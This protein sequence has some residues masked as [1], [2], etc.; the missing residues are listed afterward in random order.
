MDKS[1]KAL[2]PCKT[3]PWR[4]KNNATIIPRYDHNKACDLTATVSRGDDLRP[5]MACHKSTDKTMIA[6]K[7]Y[8]AREGWSNINVR[9]MLLHGQIDNPSDVMGAIEANGVELEM[10]YD[11]VLKKLAKSINKDYDLLESEL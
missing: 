5:V 2:L 7:G 3:C 8:L 6:C 9:L 1:N 10:C 11:D 4:V